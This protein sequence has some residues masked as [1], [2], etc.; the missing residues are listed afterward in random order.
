MSRHKLQPSTHNAHSLANAIRPSSVGPGT[1]L[2][3]FITLA[4]TRLFSQ[5]PSFLLL[6]L[7]FFSS[8]SFLPCFSGPRSDVFDCIEKA[9]DTFKLKAI[10]DDSVESKSYE[11]RSC[12]MR[13]AF[14][15]VSL[16]HAV[17]IG[18]SATAFQQRATSFLPRRA[19]QL[20]VTPDE[21]GLSPAEAFLSQE[22]PTFFNL[23]ISPNEEVTKKLRENANIGFTIFAP[24]EAAFAALG[25]KRNKQLRDPRNLEAVQKMGAYHVIGDEAVTSETLLSP[26]VGG[27]L[28]IGGEVEVGPSQSGGF[29]GI[30][31][32]NDGGVAIG[33]SGRIV[34]SFS[35]DAGIVHEVDALVSPSILW[36]YCDQLRIPGL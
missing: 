3:L 19:S 29:L 12:E 36:R 7:P 6:F 33:P 20:A 23:L 26:S 8:F 14:F 25:E 31:G 30:G 28:T 15:Y 22:Y 5:P 21:T 32:K 9:L 34:Q 10:G 1:S 2:S 11:G 18:R 4:P 24:N 17:I 13:S 35:V 27:I 16:V